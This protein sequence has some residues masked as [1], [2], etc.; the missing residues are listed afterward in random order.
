MRRHHFEHILAA[1]DGSPASEQVVSFATD[2]AKKHGATLNLVRASAADIC[3]LAS[4]IG[5]DLIVT[6][7]PES[8]VSMAVARG[9]R[10]PVLSIPV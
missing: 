7:R 2:L 3:E 8:V 4:V 9:A 5:A 6:G 10:C 1:V